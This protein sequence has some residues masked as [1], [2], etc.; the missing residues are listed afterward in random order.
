MESGTPRDRLKQL[1]P[2]K[3]ARLL[4]SLLE[5]TSLNGE[6]KQIR[7]CDR[8]D[9][10][11]LSFAQQRLWF[12]EQLEPGGSAYN[13]PTA[14]K[15]RGELKIDAL[16]QTINE[17]VRRHEA[18]RTC[19]PTL[20]E[21]PVQ[22]IAEDSSVHLQLIDLC[23]LERDEAE[24]KMASLGREDARRAFDLAAGPL[25]RVTLVRQSEEE[26]MVLLTM[27]HIISDRWSRGI[28]TGEVGRLY[29]VFG[30]GEPSP[31]IE[32]AIQYADYALW[33]R[34]YLQGEVLERQLGYW[35]KQLQDAGFFLNLPTDHPRPPV[36]SYLGARRSLILTVKLTEDLKGLG[37]NL[38]ATL[39]MMLLATF[40]VLL[41]R[42]SGQEDLLVGVPI[43]GR[44]QKETENLIGFFVNTL[45]MRGDLSGRPSFVEFLERVRETALGA[46]AHQDLP[47]EKLVEELQPERDRSR[48]PLFQVMFQLQNTPREGL[49]RQSPNAPQRMRGGGLQLQQVGS[50]TGTAMFDLT[51]TMIENGQKL[52]GVLIYDLDLFSEGTIDRM[53]GHFEN[54]L[55]GIVADPSVPVWELPLLSTAER[56][57]LWFEFTNSEIEYQNERGV[58]QEIEQ[59]VVKREEAIAL[60]DGERQLS[61]GELNRYAN[62]LAHYLKEMSVGV[63][64]RVGICLERSLEMVVGILGILKA[65]GVYVPLAPALPSERL[66]FI[67]EDA[68]TPVLVTEEGLVEREAGGVAEVV[69]LGAN[70]KTIRER[71]EENL[72]EM[73]MPDNPAYVIYTSGSTGQPKG[74]LVSHRNLMRLFAATGGEFDFSETDVWTLFHSYAFDF[75]VWEIF[76]ALLSGGRLVIVPYLIS[77]SAEDFHELMIRERVTVLNQTPSAFR[78]LMRV[79]EGAKNAGEG[80]LRWIIFGG[81]AL[82][83]QSLK[84]W[85]RRYGGQSPQLINMYGITETTVHVT[86][87]QVG[88]GDVE[89]GKGSVVGRAIEDLQIYLMDG[90]MNLVPSRM[91]GEMYV[92]GGGV[93]RGYL[94]RADLTAERFI[95]NP[96]SKRAG[97]ILYKTGDVARYQADG[98]VEFIGRLDNQ[99]KVRG[100]RIELGEIEAVLRGH[101]VVKETVVVAR[102]DEPGEKRLVAYVVA[103]EEKQS[104]LN[105]EAEREADGERVS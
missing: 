73:V 34:E 45:V 75:S 24:Q 81:E 89:N 70:W 2:A 30:E 40:Q 103:E 83:L 50:G 53:L 4:K 57:Q 55:S 37:R 58:H 15:L 88:A 59:Q 11:P 102:E 99:V 74:T 9:F 8:S 97:G 65:G 104:G 20:D 62:R 1:S 69:Y 25:L 51:L 71:G 7:R 90:H 35:R 60:V 36:S 33:Q 23:G 27:H 28:L 78:E 21:G 77:R 52:E 105:A 10:I 47:F 64:V 101:P 12:L 49:V 82:E 87:Y 67:L 14:V 86:Y 44:T 48:S 38:R 19:F 31:L 95:P 98:M 96:Y 26:H 29:T 68:Q 32:F 6:S 17:I 94:R 3:K 84:P 16:I 56:E 22:R 92:G 93:S 42:Y 41:P 13:L 46:Y 18:L 72:A 61:Y 79:D 85:F 39:F 63:E 5:E 80:S 91:M 76:G 100:Y 66:A 43:A 54:L